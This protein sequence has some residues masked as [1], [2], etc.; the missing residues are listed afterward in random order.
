MNN[1]LRAIQYKRW[2]SEWLRALPL[3]WALPVD[4]IFIVVCML[5]FLYLMLKIL[6]NIRYDIIQESGI[7]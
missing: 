7:I 2:V 4:R 3:R 1:S 5:A 6:L